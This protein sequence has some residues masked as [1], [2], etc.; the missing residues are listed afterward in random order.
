[1]TESP[2]MFSTFNRWRKRLLYEMVGNRRETKNGGFIMVMPIFN[3][4]AGINGKHHLG[5]S[6]N[7]KQR[8]LSDYTHWKMNPEI[9]EPW[10]ISLTEIWEDIGSTVPK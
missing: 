10:H 9:W 3:K 7:G 8:Q 5:H 4:L 6:I 2:V 1:M